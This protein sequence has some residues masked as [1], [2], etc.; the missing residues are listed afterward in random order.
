VHVL[1]RSAVHPE[2]SLSRLVPT[3]KYSLVVP[4][5]KNEANLP[6]LV[7]ALD[8]LSAQ[9]EHALEV[10]FVVDGSP[11]ESFARLRE[12]L[13]ARPFASQLVLLSRNFGSFAA[14]VTGLNEA[15]G[16]FFAVMAA[17]LQEP[18]E[19]VLEFFRSL[20]HEPVDVTIGIRS[21]RSDPL[22]SSL[23]SRMYWALY[24]RF[25]QAEMPAGGVDIFGCNRAF[26]DRLIALRE[27]NSSLVGLVLWLGFRRKLVTYE[28]RK[29]EIG[30]SAWSFRKK[31]RYL[32]DSVFGFTDLPIRMLIFAGVLGLSIA[33]LLILVVLIAKLSGGIK[34]PG[35]TATVLSVTFF[36]GLNSFGLGIIGS[37]VW[38]SFENTKQRPNSVVLMKEE[39]NGK[40]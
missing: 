12:L 7:A 24:R 38:R 37:Y 22:L 39:Y 15:K 1:T 5:Y 14:I 23:S 16:D 32:S 3:V 13:V 20:E 29:R 25:V 19:L 30:K 17:D 8:D 26:R 6:S 27:S 10:V 18:P 31:L 35:Y 34:V 21:R 40:S 11:D 28:R 9:L 36:A 33:A 2:L 4:V